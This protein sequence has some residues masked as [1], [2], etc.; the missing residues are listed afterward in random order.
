MH[1]KDLETLVKGPAK[2]VAGWGG[3]GGGPKG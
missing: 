3:D 1:R 2:D